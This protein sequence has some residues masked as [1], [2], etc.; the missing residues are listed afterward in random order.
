[1]EAI[2]LDVFTK[3]TNDVHCRV[4]VDRQ[5]R[6]LDGFVSGRVTNVGDIFFR[7]VIVFLRSL[8]TSSGL[9]CRLENG[10]ECRAVHTYV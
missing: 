8:P 9:L 3:L 2:R 10:T 5:W 7:V 1:L 6:K 4:I